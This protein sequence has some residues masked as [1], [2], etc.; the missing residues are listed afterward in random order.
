[1]RSAT[2]ACS[3]VLDSFCGPIF[4]CSV[5]E[6]LL[7]AL[8]VLVVLGLAGRQL[9]KH[10]FLVPW[11]FTRSMVL[12]FHGSIL[13]VPH[14]MPLLDVVP[15]PAGRVRAAHCALLVLFTC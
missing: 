10:L 1:M 12:M 8:L 9:V 5:L 15:V 6:V 4:P 13:G 7:E 3:A 14:E 11:F 2:V